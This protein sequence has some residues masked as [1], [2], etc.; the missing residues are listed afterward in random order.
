MRAKESVA[1][2]VVRLA[3]YFFLAA[4]NSVLDILKTPS[5]SGKA[6]WYGT[7]TGSYGK[8]LA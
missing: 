1:E 8:T 2:Q 7:E 3:G 5:L 4:S 6:T